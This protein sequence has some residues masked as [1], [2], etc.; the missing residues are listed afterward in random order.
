MNSAS[1]AVVLLSGGLDSTTTLALALRDGYRAYAM[2]IRYGQRHRW[3]IEAARKIARE[4]SVAEHLVVD[5]DLR[6]FGGSAL[7]SEL[8]VPK[9][10]T[11]DQI[12]DEMI[13]RGCDTTSRKRIFS[14]SLGSA[15]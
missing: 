11:A 6:Q 8:P 12:G 4:M 15:R 7:T 9:K 14:S 2:T 5:V 3:E 13:L 1:N 10:Q